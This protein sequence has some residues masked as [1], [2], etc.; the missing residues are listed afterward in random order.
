M[1]HEFINN[2]CSWTKIIFFKLNKEKVGYGKKKYYQFNK[3][4]SLYTYNN[5][6]LFK[7]IFK[8]ALKAKK[9]SSFEQDGIISKE[10]T[11]NKFLVKFLLYDHI[12]KIDFNKKIKILDYGGSFGN[13]FFSLKK[14]INLKFDWYIC[15][16]K[17]KI[18]FAKKSSVFKPLKFIYDYEIKKNNFYDI[19]FFSS[20][21]QYLPDP[22]AKIKELKQCSKIILI[23]NA[24]LTNFN[25]S[26]LRVETPDPTVYKFKYPCWF[27][28]KSNFRN[29]LK[30]DFN[31]VFEKNNNIYPLYKGESYCNIILKKK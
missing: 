20:V 10:P 29:T 25:K 19:I 16:Q 2:I 11:P 24:I 4:N 23:N 26:Y 3:I 5:K 9:N 13:V 17:N 27:L 22:L 8:Q 30:K 12:L 14:N 7:Y 15:D 31:I 18:D 21:L 1:V 6:K 28:S